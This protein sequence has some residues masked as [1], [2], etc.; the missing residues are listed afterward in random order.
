[1][2]YKVSLKPSG[3]SFVVGDG[4]RILKAGLDAGIGMP[5]GC[6]MGT[7]NS[8]RGK[9]LSGTVDHGM[10]HPNYLTPQ[11]RAEGYALMC[12]ATALSE[13]TVELTE[14]PRLVPPTRFPAMI[15]SVA[16]PKEDVAIIN[17]RLPLH[18]NLM[19]AA[20]QHIEIILP[21]GNRRSYSI[22]NAPKTPEGTIDLQLHVRHLKGGLFTDPLF[23]P[24]G[25]AERQRFDCEGPFGS[26]LLDDS[27]APVVFVARGV[28]YAPIRSIILDVFRRNIS[29]PMVFY[30]G[31]R[32][33]KGLYALDELSSW[34]EEFPS[35][36]FV[37]VV[38]EPLAD[39]Q[40]D[41]R[42]GQ[43]YDAVCD[44]IQDLSETMVYA[45]GAPAFVS[46]T[47]SKLIGQAGLIETK[48]YSDSFVTQ[49]D[50]QHDAVVGD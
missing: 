48:F 21:D 3:H 49:A 24:G 22:A 10:A 1:M 19:F 15:R 30:W 20:G 37:P 38:A 43:V 6:R 35:F 50:V 25:L 4:D 44:D 36:K 32:T 2:N 39:E 26:F 23:G 47:K 41:G 14:T 11:D 17:L 7:C 29:R 45:C 18:Q 31:A 33:R 5:Y 9:V 13:I 46:A 28:G 40:W 34:A 27:D 42:T 16:R 8:C 12:Q